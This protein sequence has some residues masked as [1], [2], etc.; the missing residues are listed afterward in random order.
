MLKR[1]GS[2]TV[3]ADANDSPGK[4]FHCF[5]EWIEFPEWLWKEEREREM[6]SHIAE[7]IHS[8][9]AEGGGRRRRLRPVCR[10]ISPPIE[11][12]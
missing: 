6:A 5:S 12:E 3:P 11:E 8:V 9:H 4:F 10:E 1:R 7:I 2:P